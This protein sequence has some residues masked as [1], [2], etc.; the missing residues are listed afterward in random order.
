MTA[1]TSFIL[2]PTT[3]RFLQAVA[4]GVALLLLVSCNAMKLTYNGADVAIRWKVHRYFDLQGA[5]QADF[6]AR[7]A[8]FHA[9]HRS[10]ELPHYEALSRA[11]GKRLAAGLSA[12]DIQWATAALR[13]RYGVLMRQAAAEAAPVLATLTTEQI[14]HLEDELARSNRDFT[15]KYLAGSEEKRLKERI[16]RNEQ[17]FAEW[18]GNLTT[19]Q[20]TRIADMVRA[21]P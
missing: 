10:Q 16:K 4:S 5:Q 20:Q 13:E 6:L 1:K 19:E 21:D 2:Q 17:H 3:V 18:I 8:R 11:A 15:K 9:W 12:E 7:L 14:A